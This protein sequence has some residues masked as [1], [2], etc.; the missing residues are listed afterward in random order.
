[1]TAQLAE[2]QKALKKSGDKELMDIAENGMEDLTAG[3]GSRLEES[4]GQLDGLEGS[5]LRR[6]SGKA[7]II[8]SGFRKHIGSDVAVK[9]CDKNPFKIPV[10]MQSTLEA[11]LEKLDKTLAS[12]A[13][14]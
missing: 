14:E 13:A 6:A 12:A 10:A 7:R 4:L 9:A 11:A 8:I 5:A 2:L 3:F 1:V